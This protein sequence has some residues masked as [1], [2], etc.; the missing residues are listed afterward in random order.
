MQKTGGKI[1]SDEGVY[2]GRNRKS[3]GKSQ[4]ALHDD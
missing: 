1:L 3:R 2:R 4:C